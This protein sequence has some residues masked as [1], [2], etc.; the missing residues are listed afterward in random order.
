MALYKRRKPRAPASVRLSGAKATA[1]QHETAVTRSKTGA[2]AFPRIAGATA[3]RMSAA[4]PLRSYAALRRPSRC[5]AH[6]LRREPILYVVAHVSPIGPKA[7]GRH[8]VFQT[9][10][11][12]VGRG[13][14]RFKRRGL[15]VMRRKQR[16]LRSGRAVLRRPAIR[17]GRW[18]D[19]AP[20][21]RLWTL[22]RVWGQR[23]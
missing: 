9:P 11:W 4:A 16:R 13:G 17:A 20:E 19:A 3:F 15:F 6:E 10:V 8:S 18:P 23:V 21:C 12:D 7:L 2:F 22:W 5:A 14:A 1:G